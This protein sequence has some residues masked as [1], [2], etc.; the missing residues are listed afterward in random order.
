M[1]LRQ[2]IIVVD[3]YESQN[4]IHFTGSPPKRGRLILGSFSLC[5]GCGCIGRVVALFPLWESALECDQVVGQG[6]VQQFR[7]TSS[8]NNAA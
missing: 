8:F 7:A 5:G 2:A 1:K 4:D 6:C 3:W